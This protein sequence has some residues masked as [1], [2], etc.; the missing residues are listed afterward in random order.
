MTTFNRRISGSADVVL[1]AI[2]EAAN[3]KFRKASVSR[4][5]NVV[6][7]ESKVLWQTQTTTFTVTE[8]ELEA[9][10][11]NA[12]A[13]GRAVKVLGE[14]FHLIDDQGWQASMEKL[15]TKS[16]KNQAIRDQVL[17][18]VH[19][20]EV[21]VAATQGLEL[22]K[23]SIVVATQKRI[24]LLEKDTLGFSSGSR[25]IALDKISSI[26]ASKGMLFGGIVITTSNEEIKVEKV[27]GDEVDAFVGAVRNALETPT[28]STPASS[29]SD[30]DQLTK[31]AELH[32]AGILTDDEFAAAKA[33]ALGL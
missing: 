24:L 13:D 5:G 11:N 19:S 10:G 33:K 6:T 2:E 21:I 15:G 18:A 32:A 28:T 12:D 7:V 30:L 16:V 20:D 31:L 1:S 29:S 3:N 25:T 23:T 14:I 4:A 27:V 22:K 9:A 8:Q 17:N 26:T